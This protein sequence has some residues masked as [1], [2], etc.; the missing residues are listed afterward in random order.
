MKREQKGGKRLTKGWRR[1]KHLERKMWDKDEIKN[2]V[3][4]TEGKRKI[5]KE[6]ELK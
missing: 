6:V 4:E 1:R 2:L 3:I 5:D